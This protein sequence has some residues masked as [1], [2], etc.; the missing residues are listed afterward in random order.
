VPRPKST[1]NDEQNFPL[2]FNLPRRF[3]ER[4]AAAHEEFG[5]S[6]TKL[7]MRGLELAIKEEETKRAGKLPDAKRP[8]V[9]D[10]SLSDA[11]RRVAEMRWQATSEEERK[12]VGRRLAE[13]RWGKKRPKKTGKS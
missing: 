2:W 5:V 1:T 12:Q 9:S 8:T 13:A 4:L 11:L 7:M 6:R 10:E 3:Y